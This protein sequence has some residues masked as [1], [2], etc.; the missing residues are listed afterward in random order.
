MSEKS[1]KDEV[2]IV[3]VV[4]TADKTTTPKESNKDNIEKIR[5]ENEGLRQ[6]Q[7]TLT[8]SNEEIRKQLESLTNGLKAIAGIEDTIEGESETDKVQKTLE[9][10]NNKVSS[11]EKER[12]VNL[13]LEKLSGADVPSVVIDKVRA[14]INTSG[15]SADEIENAVIETADDFLSIYQ[16]G[17]STAKAVSRPEKTGGNAKD[18]GI[19]FEGIKIRR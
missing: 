10:L 16:E 2:V 14:K 8:K 13:A 19:S 9:A 15:L 3:D 1:K 17:L 7:S 5:Q 12:A 18:I 4:K 11:L 6:A